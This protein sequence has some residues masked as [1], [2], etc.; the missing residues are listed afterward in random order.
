[1]HR[2][3][4]SNNVL[5]RSQT[6]DS[7]GYICKVRPCTCPNTLQDVFCMGQRTDQAP[8]YSACCKGGCLRADLRLWAVTHPGCRQFA[9]ERDVPRHRQLDASGGFYLLVL[10]VCLVTKTH[11]KQF[12]FEVSAA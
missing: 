3:L 11:L 8:E 7:R 10:V 6:T 9:C 5:L 12:A 2:D 4:K 1:M